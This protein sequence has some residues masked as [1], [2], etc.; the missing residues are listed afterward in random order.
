[1]SRFKA[2]LG[3]GE[4]SCAPST[5]TDTPDLRSTAEKA[6]TA[7]K[8]TVTPADEDEYEVLRNDDY[9]QA[10]AKTWLVKIVKRGEEWIEEIENEESEERLRRE[11]VV[12]G[13]AGERA[14]FFLSLLLSGRVSLVLLRRRIPRLVLTVRR[15][16]DACYVQLFWRFGLVLRVGFFI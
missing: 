1:M 11:E 10:A 12:E 8:S 9:E 7:T 6:L 2:I 5:S 16:L 15:F 14:S 13:A 3:S 4:E